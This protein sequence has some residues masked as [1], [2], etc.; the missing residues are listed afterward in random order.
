M[1]TYIHNMDISRAA[2]LRDDEVSYLSLPTEMPADITTGSLLKNESMITTLE[3]LSDSTSTEAEVA[4][5]IEEYNT[6][7]FINNPR[8]LPVHTRGSSRVS[9]GLRESSLWDDGET[10]VTSAY[11]SPRFQDYVFNGGIE[12]NGG[13][14]TSNLSTK[15]GKHS[16]KLNLHK[17][18]THSRVRSNSRS[19]STSTTVSNIFSDLERPRNRSLSLSFPWLVRSTTDQKSGNG[20]SFSTSSPKV[21]SSRRILGSTSCNPPLSNHRFALSSDRKHNNLQGFCCLVIDSLTDLDKLESDLEHVAADNDEI[22]ETFIKNLIEL[23]RKDDVNIETLEK[24]LSSD[25][26]FSQRDLCNLQELR[27]RRNEKWADIIY[28]YQ[29]LL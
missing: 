11:S 12:G 9:G 2:P 29:N 14:E 21:V 24:K 20:G 22:D 19:R 26:W 18:R 16:F 27:V 13:D 5:E 10:A 1:T 3:T 25:G 4:S 7:V 8:T 6:T 28:G 17:S 23:Q 15:N